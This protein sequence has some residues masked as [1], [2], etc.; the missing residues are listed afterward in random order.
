MSKR[1]VKKIKK[2]S[3][4]KHGSGVKAD[5]KRQI[6]KWQGRDKKLNRRVLEDIQTDIEDLPQN[7]VIFSELKEI[8]N[9]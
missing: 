8:E 7:I 1:M 6:I 4:K 9:I 3:E 5:D 2:K